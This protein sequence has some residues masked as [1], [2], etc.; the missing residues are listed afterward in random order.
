M[1]VAFAVLREMASGRAWPIIAFSSAAWAL[2][3]GLDHSVLVPSLCSP[4][5]TANWIGSSAFVAVISINDLAA[6]TFSWFVMLL[7]MMTPLIWQQLTHVWD[8]SLAERRVRA[9]LLF[10]GGYFGVW[11]IA[12]AILALLVVALRLA[13][14]SGIVAFV[15]GLGLFV[16]WQMTPIKARFLK[17]CHRLR[18]LPAFGL[19]ADLASFRY[20]VEISGSCVVTCW[21]IMLLP[22]TSDVAHIPMMGTATLLMLS[23]RYLETRD[24]CLPTPTQIYGCL[25]RNRK[26]SDV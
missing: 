4:N 25:F 14:A 18:P 6:Q 7:A 5:S 10:L 17:R 13:A 11:M 24:F 12:M 26:M 19:S 1:I 20:G 21:A 23:E 2:V 9:V 8:R 3:I 16:L 22:F 15:I